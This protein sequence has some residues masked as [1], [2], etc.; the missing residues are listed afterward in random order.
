MSTGSSLPVRLLHV[1]LGGISH[2]AARLSAWLAV[3]LLLSGFCVSLAQA[4]SRNPVRARTPLEIVA[5]DSVHRFA[6]ELART[7]D[8]RA[9]GL[10]YRTRLA[11]DAGMLFLFPRPVMASF[12]MHN[13]L[14]S[15]D[16]LFIS[17][18]GRIVNI[19][20]EAEPL[21]LDSRRSAAPVVAVLELAGG[22]AA[23]LGIMPGDR[24]RHAALKTAL[25]PR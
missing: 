22:R 12:W 4:D 19:V 13:T 15:L 2:V 5:A 9:M 11:D 1:R 25:P 23:A 8:E 7:P 3:A 14:I 24:V 18:D 16:M 21:T 20:A 10:M 6:V 17:A